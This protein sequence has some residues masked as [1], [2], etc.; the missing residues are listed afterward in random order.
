MTSSETADT[1]EDEDAGRDARGIHMEIRGELREQLDRRGSS[2]DLGQVRLNF[3]W[4]VMSISAEPS[5]IKGLF[6]RRRY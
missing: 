1:G 2:L 6:D 5:T 3:K 4:V